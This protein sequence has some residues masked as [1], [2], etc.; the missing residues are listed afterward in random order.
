MKTNSTAQDSDFVRIKNVEDTALPP[1]QLEISFGPPSLPLPPELL[2]DPLTEEELIPVPL[3][4]GTRSGQRTAELELPELELVPL[5]PINW[6]G[7]TLGLLAGLGLGLLLSSR[8]LQDF[9]SR[10]LNSLNPW[11]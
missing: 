2:E 11:K 7:W 3:V 8:E 4:G 9:V 1:N 6:R 5:A 10:T